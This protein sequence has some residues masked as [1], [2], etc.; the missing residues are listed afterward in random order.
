MRI[1]TLTLWP[2]LA[3]ALTSACGG[4]SPEPAEPVETPPETSGAENPEPVVLRTTTPVP[5]PQPA[6]AREELAD[7]LQQLWTRTEEIVAAR[8][9]E[10]PTE[11]TTEALEAWANDPFMP[12]VDGRRQSIE[13][14]EPFVEAIGDDPVQRSVAAALFGYMYEDTAA[15]IRGAPVPEDIAGDPELLEI[16]VQTLDE[17]LHPFAQRALESYAYCATTLAGLG[18]TPW[19]SWASYCLDRGR[20]VGEVFELGAAAEE[21]GADGAEEG[22]EA[23]ATSD[24]PR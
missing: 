3:I 9:P 2:V 11:G 17:A 13:E 23:S 16:Y 7:P 21:G 5:V 6:V 19:I 10:P 24:S 20:D 14:V 12:W 1:R 22:A 4:S 15:G 18:E 8:P